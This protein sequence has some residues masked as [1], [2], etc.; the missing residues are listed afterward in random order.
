[1]FNTLLAQYNDKPESVDGGMGSSTGKGMH[2]E[3]R[4]KT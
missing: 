3:N 1:M 4:K 2:Q